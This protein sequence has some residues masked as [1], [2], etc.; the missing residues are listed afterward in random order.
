M[1]DLRRREY[2]VY[3]SESIVHVQKRGL[4]EVKEFT[5]RIIELIF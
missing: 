3:K 1:R 5:K 4:T 2:F